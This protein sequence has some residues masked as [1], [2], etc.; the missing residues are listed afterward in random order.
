MQLASPSELH[1]VID[2][3]G[4]EDSILGVRALQD[5]VV[6]RFE[7]PAVADVS[8]VEPVLLPKDVGDLRGEVLIEQQFDVHAGAP[9]AGRPSCRRARTRCPRP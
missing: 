2:V 7:K 6:L 9:C 1:E 4:R 5:L 3:L 8:S